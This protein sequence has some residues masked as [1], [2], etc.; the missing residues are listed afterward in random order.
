MKDKDMEKKNNFRRAAQKVFINEIIEGILIV[1]EKELISVLKTSTKK[2]YRLNVIA[3]VVGKEK[4]GSA[5]NLLIDD[6]TSKITIRFF[7]DND[8]AN[9]TVIGDVLLI[10]G[11]TRSYQEE[12]YISPEIVKKVD[13]LWL[14]VRSL[15]LASLAHLKKENEEKNDKKNEEKNDENKQYEYNLLH[16]EKIARLIKEMDAGEGVFIEEIIEKS[17]LRNIEKILEKMMEK[18][19]IFQNQPGRVKA[20]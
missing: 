13:P 16:F 18:G 10:I 9:A 6:S 19:D 7:E 4:R 3:V 2:I 12:K 8:V 17:S 1:E 11:K 5:T 20:L 15:E 14:K